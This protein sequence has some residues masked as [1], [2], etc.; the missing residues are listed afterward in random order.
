LT[1]S[2]PDICP[3]SLAAYIDLL[4]FQIIQCVPSLEKI[5][6]NQTNVPLLCPETDLLD[7][8]EWVGTAALNIK[9]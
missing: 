7:I 4:G 9:W 8:V 1:I 3:S 5:I 6:L 2:D